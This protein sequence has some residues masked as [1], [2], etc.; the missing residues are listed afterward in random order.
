MEKIT[1]E[2]E[3]IGEEGWGKEVSGVIET[4]GEW[5]SAKLDQLE[6]S[7]EGK[8]V[9][10]ADIVNNTWAMKADALGAVGIV[11]AGVSLDP[12]PPIPIL[13]MPHDEL[14]QMVKRTWEEIVKRNGRQARMEPQQ[15]KLTVLESKE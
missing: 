6:S 4:V 1:S 3:F 9:V 14:G 10:T 12:I 13:T 7:I 5:G 8:I 15:K 2:K 11:A